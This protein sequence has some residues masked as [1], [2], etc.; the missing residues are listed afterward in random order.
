VVVVQSKKKPLVKN[1]ASIKSLAAY[2]WILNPSGC[3]YRA[4]L[5]RAM[6][7]VG[8]RLRLGVDAHATDMQLRLVSA[9]VGLGLVPKEVLATSSFKSQLSVVDV[10]DFKLT[11]DMCVVSAKELGNLKQVVDFVDDSLGAHFSRRK[12]G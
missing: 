10:R 4:A 11:V 7:G 9:G 12:R 1:R 2:E 3:N 8:Q 5:E 6:D